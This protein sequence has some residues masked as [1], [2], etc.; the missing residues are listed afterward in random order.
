MVHGAIQLN[1]SVEHSEMSNSGLFGTTMRKYCVMN[2][3]RACNCEEYYQKIVEQNNLFGLDDELFQQNYI[4]LCGDS[5]E[6]AQPYK[7]YS[8]GETDE[9]HCTV[10]QFECVKAPLMFHMR[11]DT[12]LHLAIEETKWR[13]GV[14]GTEHGIK[15]PKEVLKISL[16]CAEKFGK[17]VPGVNTCQQ[18]NNNI[19]IELG[20]QPRPTFSKKWCVLV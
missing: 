1:Q 3:D 17:Y 6:K 8:Y 16:L 15:S 19:L 13:P 2:Q 14:N 9:H 4:T 11:Y 20:H 5:W 7:I 10:V 12:E 18:L